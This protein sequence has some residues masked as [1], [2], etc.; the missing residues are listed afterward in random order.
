MWP[1]KRT[2]KRK[3]FCLWRQLMND[4]DNDRQEKGSYDISTYIDFT[5]RSIWRHEIKTWI[6]FFRWCVPCGTLGSSDWIGCGEHRGRRAVHGAR[7]HQHHHDQLHLWHFCH[8]FS[9]LL[10]ESLWKT[11]L[12]LSWRASIGWDGLER[13]SHDWV[14]GVAGNNQETVGSSSSSRSRRRG[15]RASN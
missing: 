11:C 8:S 1:C 13:K 7:H 5:C 2:A 3:L 10:P 4:D 12:L 6:Y 9:M 14:V 15:A